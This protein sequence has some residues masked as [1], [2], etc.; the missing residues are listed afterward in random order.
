MTPPAFETAD[1]REERR[2]RAWREIDQADA[3]LAVYDRMNGPYVVETADW[4]G[5]QMRD[6]GKQRR[7]K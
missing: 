6:S 7:R 2:K 1:E 4:E 5:D 3:H